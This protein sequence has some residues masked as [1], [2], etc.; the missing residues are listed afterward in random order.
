MGSSASFSSRTAA[1]ALLAAYIGVAVAQ[2]VT[3]DDLKIRA[4]A[5]DKSATR[6][7]A[8]AY[9]LGREGAEQNF[10]EAARWYVKLA[11]Q[12]DRRA[13]T[14]LGL[15]YIR[16]YGVKKDPAEAFRW[17]SF[18]AAGNDPGAQYNLGT[19]YRTG[20]GV[21]QDFTQA[22]KWFRQAAQRG[23][24]QAQHDLGM[25]YYEGNGVEKDSRWAYYWVKVAALQGDDKAEES[26]KKVS[27]G[28]SADQI[29]EADRQAT[30]WMAKAKK[31]LK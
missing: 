18:A 2:N 7:L 10:S 29:R 24:V 28:M 19:L 5:G 6:Q 14:T 3:L 16:G 31:L 23:H 9:Y 13:Q 4:E 25:L 12:G 1:C 15:M 27:A 26:L 17:W 11:Q 22:A 21:Q 30:E 8:E 20:S